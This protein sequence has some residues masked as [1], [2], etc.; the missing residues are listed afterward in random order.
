MRT[1]SCEVN[2]SETVSLSLSCRRE[3]INSSE[4]SENKSQVEKL[5]NC[6]P[7]G[8]QYFS[9]GPVITAC[10]KNALKSLELR[11][12]TFLS[13][14]VQP[15]KC[16]S[17]VCAT[18]ETMFFFFLPKLPSVAFISSDSTL[19]WAPTK[20]HKDTHTKKC[21]NHRI[22]MFRLYTRGADSWAERC[23]YTET[24]FHISLLPPL[25]VSLPLSSRL[26]LR[27]CFITLLFLSPSVF[28]FLYLLSALWVSSPCTHAQIILYSNATRWFSQSQWAC[29]QT[30]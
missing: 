27:L 29:Y 25:P 1:S 28:S 3:S 20:R 9:V 16:F 14:G 21:H 23:D 22:L 8:R 17:F 24:H 4:V 18:G 19:L 7:S 15:D 30:H 12:Y 26:S 11:G 10:G 13:T 6:F 2:R 5:R